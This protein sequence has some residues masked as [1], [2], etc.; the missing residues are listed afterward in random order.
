MK[1]IAVH[2]HV[3]DILDAQGST[4][5]PHWCHDLS[6]GALS[7]HFTDST[8]T[9]TWSADDIASW[10]RDGDP[11]PSSPRARVLL[12]RWGRVRDLLDK[13]DRR[14]PDQL[15]VDDDE[16]EFTL[17]WEEEKLAVIIGPDGKQNEGGREL[18]ALD[19]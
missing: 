16:Q 13:L 14:H 15:L 6:T 17:L 12:T 5:P 11:G 4:P 3:L 1:T 10:H 9:Y 2:A 18:E 8:T 7:F 19:R